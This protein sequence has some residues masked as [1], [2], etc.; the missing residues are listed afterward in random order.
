M[1]RSRSIIVTVGVLALT[2]G[3]SRNASADS[4]HFC[5]ENTDGLFCSSPA[6][7]PNDPDFQIAL[8]A[9]SEGQWLVW[10]YPNGTD[11]E[12]EQVGDP[13]LETGG[14]LWFNLFVDGGRADDTMEVVNQYGT[15][16]CGFPLDP[17]MQDGYSVTFEGIAGEDLIIMGHDVSAA[18]GDYCIGQNETTGNTVAS[19][20]PAATLEGG[21]GDDFLYLIPGVHPSN[22][23]FVAAGAGNDTIYM[24][25]TT[26][27]LP[28][29]TI[30]DCGTGFDTYCGPS[31]VNHNNTCETTDNLCNGY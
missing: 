12:W 20:Y 31:A 7:S 21:G 5:Y 8:G 30:I 9:D 26:N 14:G 28:S 23:L 1:G 19:Y 11:C 15:S 4:A 16:Y 13:Y 3:L 22:G 6:Y 17:P 29:D 24:S 2:L 27:N 25:K 10:M 18:C